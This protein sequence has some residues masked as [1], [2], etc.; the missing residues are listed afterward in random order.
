VADEH[1]ALFWDGPCAKTTR[2][3]DPSDYLRAGQYHM[4]DTLTC[5][6]K[7]YIRGTPPNDLDP[8]YFVAGGKYAPG[9]ERIVGEH[10]LFVA[11]GRL[12]KALGPNTE[13]AVAR[14]R[15]ARRRMRRAVK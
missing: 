14:I 13:R 7:T 5:G 9:V 6:G 12:Q 4:P 11:W 3:I 15:R 1:F 2:K 8:T 10:D